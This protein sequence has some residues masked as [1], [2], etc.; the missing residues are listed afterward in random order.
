MKTNLVPI[1]CIAILFAFVLFVLGCFFWIVHKTE[2]IQFYPLTAI[3][4]EF[5]YDN[6]LVTCIDGADNF[7]SF[8]GIDDWHMGDFVSMIMSDNGT[9]TIYDDII[10]QTEY[11]GYF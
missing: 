3:V 9:P 5:D 8:H 10:L 7:W 4:M 11:A 1:I 6:D 2:Q